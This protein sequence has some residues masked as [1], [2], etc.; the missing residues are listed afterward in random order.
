[1]KIN[2]K[3]GGCGERGKTWGKTNI[4]VMAGRH[5]EMELGEREAECGKIECGAR[6]VKWKFQDKRRDK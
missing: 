5:R 4:T 3:R 1:M 2:Q 6:R